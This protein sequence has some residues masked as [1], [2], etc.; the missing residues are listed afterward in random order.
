MWPTAAAAAAASAAAVP[1]PGTVPPTAALE[2]APPAAANDAVQAAQLE[3]LTEQ[4]EDARRQA[5]AAN[6]NAARLQEALRAAEDELDSLHETHALT[7]DELQQSNIAVSSA[8]VQAESLQR[9][10]RELQEA[11]A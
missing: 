8:K 1:P 6:E 5:A 9:Q 10:L 7:W 3:R 11:R 4:L 2:A